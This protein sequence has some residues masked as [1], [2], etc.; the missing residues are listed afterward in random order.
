MLSTN[1]PDTGTEAIVAAPTAA[2]S[3][4]FRVAIIGRPN[5]GKSTLFNFLTRSRK[6]VVK[7]QPG[8]TRDILVGQAD[9]W[10]QSFEILD[11]GGLTSSNDEFSAMIYEQVMSILK[12]VDML[13]VVMDAK[14]GRLPEDRDVIRIAKESGKPFFV[15]VNKVDRENEAEML[16]AEFYEYS[17]EIMHASFEKRDHTAEIVEKILA[18]IPPGTTAEKTGM[19]IA[20][21]GKPNAGKSS[22]FNSIVGENRV[23][24]SEIAG[25]T[26]DAVEDSFTYKNQELILIDTAGLRKQAK[27]LSRGDDVEII[28]AFK[29]YEAID[30][31][32]IV[33]LVLDAMLGP[34]EQDAKM[35]QYAYE[36]FKTVILVANKFDL[37][38]KNHP[39][40]KRWFRER[41]EREFHFAPDVPIV[42]TCAERGEGVENMLDEVLAIWQKLGLKIPTRKLNDFFYNVIRQAPSPV[43]RTVNVKFYYLT[44]TEQRPPS[45]I[46][47]ANHPEGVTPAYRRFLIK[48]IQAEWGLEGIPIRVFIM[49]SS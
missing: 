14:S 22:L 12:Y 19:R 26:I 46:A 11:T 3:R 47:F 13:V 32:D 49:K 29:S 15:V 24:V 1:E 30:R 33:L 20:I 39:E 38:K 2:L 25:T 17:A 8:V 6:A 31:C 16:K 7:N 36:K 43:Y 48:R 45:F 41:I 42:F 23:L 40:P 28:S 37:L 9:W 35:A 27:R 5:V 10:G 44:Q 21:V 4:A 18:H 34:T